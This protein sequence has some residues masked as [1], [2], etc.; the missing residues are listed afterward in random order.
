MTDLSP[1]ERVLIALRSQRR[2]PVQHGDNWQS[3]CPAHEDRIASLSISVGRDGCVLLK[4]HASCTNE[5]VLSA[6]SLQWADLFTEPKVPSN[7]REIVATYDYTDEA[8]DVLYRVVRYS[9]KD[10]RQCRPDGNGGWVWNLKGVQRVPYRLPDL[11][12]GIAADRWIF[13]CEGE[14]DVEALRNEGFVATTN[15]GGAE[16]WPGD[17]APRFKSAKVAILP[18]NDGPGRQHAQTVASSL[19]GVAT[20]VKVIELPGLPDKG[21][22]TDWLVAGGTADE[23]KALLRD[24]HEW[25]STSAPEL[26]RPEEGHSDRS[27]VLTCMDDVERERVDWLW[28]GRLPLGK[29]SVLD[30]DPG[31]GK[32]TV[33]IDIASRVSTGSPMPDGSPLDGPMGVI[34][35]SAEDGKADTIRP[36]L[37]AHGADLKRV[38]IL[39]GVRTE[40][41][42][43]GRPWSLP[44]DL[45]TLRQAMIETDAKLVVIDPLMAFLGGEVQSSRDQDVRRALHPLAMLAEDR[46]AAILV[47]RH[48]NKSVGGNALYR[49]G[50]SIGIVGA[51][52]VGLLIAGDPEDETETRRVLA[53]SKSN[54]AE[55]ADSLAYHLETDEELACGRIR[56]DGA[57]THTAAGLLSIPPND[58][59]RSAQGEAVEF[60]REFLADGPQPAREVIAAAKAIGISESTL[61]KSKRRAGVTTKRDGFGPGHQSRWRLD[62]ASVGSDAVRTSNDPAIDVIPASAQ[63]LA[64][65]TGMDPFVASMDESGSQK[66]GPATASVTLAPCTGCGQE[67]HRRND[68]GLPW[69]LL[70]EAGVAS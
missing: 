18:D 64:G 2:N 25:E 44:G 60:L 7:K 12:A 53:V 5:A 47:V 31:L 51:A 68:S 15:A 26:S 29:V 6:L 57:S 50:G 61:Q 8:G 19:Q 16:K 32:S 69:C 21:D 10:F 28:P 65:M 35:L 22:V 13:V 48:L 36:R 55:K 39:E 24:T 70:C 38:H 4:C 62:D 43:Q 59:E 40:N 3:Q 1:V 58:D 27:P 33:T 63:G 42:P 9:P 45:D 34:L 66:D 67:T 17:W 49:G 46:G 41:G 14:K 56:W 23:L 54:L 52:R 20:V 30:G 37:E 11:V